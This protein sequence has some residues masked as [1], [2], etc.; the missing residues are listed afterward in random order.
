MIKRRGREREREPKREGLV[1]LCIVIVG[2]LCFYTTKMINSLLLSIYF[3]IIINMII[4]KFI[5]FYD[6]CSL[7]Q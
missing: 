6:Y 2:F 4:F 5:T 7:S 3:F 1:Y